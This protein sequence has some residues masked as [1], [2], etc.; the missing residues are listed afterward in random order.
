MASCAV[1][2][3]MMTTGQS[4]PLPSTNVTLEPTSGVLDSSCVG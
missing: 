2:E 3:N 4:E 1:T